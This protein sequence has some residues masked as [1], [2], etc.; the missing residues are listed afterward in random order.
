MELKHIN[1][2]SAGIILNDF[3]SLNKKVATEGYDLFETGQTFIGT[4]T[5]LHDRMELTVFIVRMDFT[6]DD[7]NKP[8][9]VS[10]EDYSCLYL[11]KEK[12]T[13][14]WSDTL[15]VNET[16]KAITHGKAYESLRKIKSN[17]IG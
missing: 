15:L 16:I 11:R 14:D 12:K 10:S 9:D 3:D 13:I 7:R 5:I 17:L 8:K 1:E 6:T 4:V 2:Y